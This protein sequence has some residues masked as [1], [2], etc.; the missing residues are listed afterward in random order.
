M[1]QKKKREIKHYPRKRKPR[2]K[3]TH[4]TPPQIHITENSFAAFFTKKKQQIPP[5][6]KRLGK[7]QRKSGQTI[8]KKLENPMQISIYHTFH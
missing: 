8:Q 2:R 1:R 4:T 3:N 7:L 5:H 6:K